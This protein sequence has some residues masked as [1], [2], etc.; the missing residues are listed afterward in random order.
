[1][2]TITIK[3]DSD[4][5]AREVLTHLGYLPEDDLPDLISIKRDEPEEPESTD[6]FSFVKTTSSRNALVEQQNKNV[7][8]TPEPIDEGFGTTI[9]QTEEDKKDKKEMDVRTKAAV[10][11]VHC[12]HEE[13]LAYLEKEMLIHDDPDI[14]DV[15]KELRVKEEH[16]EW[17]SKQLK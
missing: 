13:Y 1:M 14:T 6:A 3:I 5:L 11:R 15:L 16:I 2:A 10:V 12:D 4:E 8:V 7:I 9:D 17:V